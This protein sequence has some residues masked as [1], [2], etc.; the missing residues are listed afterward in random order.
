M[1]YRLLRSLPLH[2]CVRKY[3]CLNYV[4]KTTWES[5]CLAIRLQIQNKV[6]CLHLGINPWIIYYQHP[7]QEGHFSFC[8]ICHPEFYILHLSV[9]ALFW[10]LSCLVYSCSKTSLVSCCLSKSFG[11]TDN[12][13]VFP[14]L[15]CKI[16]EM[17]N[18]ATCHSKYAKLHPSY[19]YPKGF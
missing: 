2:P 8:H 11:A 5:K 1:R 6:F 13:M 17:Q 9:C 14:L 7:A 15:T 19:R 10:F 16:R 12:A 18:S 4:L 3:M